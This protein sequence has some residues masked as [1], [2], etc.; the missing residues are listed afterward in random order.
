VKNVIGFYPGCTLKGSSEEYYK[1]A[2]AVLK[3]LGYELRE[4]EGWIC[5]G[6]TSAHSLNK[7][8]S[9]AL[10]AYNLELARRE[11]YSYIAVACAACFNRLKTAN[12]YYRNK[13]SI[14]DRIND[15]IKIDYNGEV[16]VKHLLEIL[17]D[18][19]TVSVIKEHIK[20]ELKELNVAPYYGCL[21]L[22]PPKIMEFDNVENPSIMEEV[23]GVTGAKIVDFPMKIE[24][25]GAGLTMG[26]KRSVT[27][28]VGKIVE[29][30]SMYGADLIA[31]ACPECH[32]NLDMRQFDARK[33]YGF[34]I[35]IPILFFTQVLGLALG[36]TVKELGIEK[37]L[38]DPLMVLR[39]KGI[40]V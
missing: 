29:S 26:A 28:L 34:N 22:R 15:K 10:P 37:I 36:L 38:N 25:C 20:I 23:L 27:R 31:V 7:D 30:S 39:Q 18:E 8:L 4:I 11:G 5:C 2:K 24:C 19:I 1:S 14:R 40:V 16:E 13:P 32:L 3:V 17:R 35:K 12:Y 33:Y 21:L 9:I 6:A